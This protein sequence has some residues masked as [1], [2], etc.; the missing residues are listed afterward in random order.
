[1]A[2]HSLSLVNRQ[3]MDLTGVTNVITFDEAEI[4]LA[5]TLGYLSVVGEELHIGML[6]LDE[7]RVAIQGN[8]NSVFYKPQGTDFKAKGKN[9]LTRLLK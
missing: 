7:G 1:M 4:I 3:R 2:E 6:N 5:T 9:I 8:V